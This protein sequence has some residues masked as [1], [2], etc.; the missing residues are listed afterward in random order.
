MPGQ[1]AT[2]QT[3]FPR[4]PDHKPITLLD[5]TGV[6]LFARRCLALGRSCVGQPLAPAFVI[7]MHANWSAQLRYV[8]PEEPAIVRRRM[9]VRRVGY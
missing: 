7:L 5:A 4:W 2:G 9:S 6:A 1:Y 8:K 3:T